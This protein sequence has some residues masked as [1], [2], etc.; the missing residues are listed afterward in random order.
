LKPW[1]GEKLSSKGSVATFAV[2]LVSYLKK[3]YTTVV[4]KGGGPDGNGAPLVSFENIST[5]LQLLQ[6]LDPSILPQTVTGLDR[7]IST[8]PTLGEN[9]RSLIEVCLTTH[10]S[11]RSSVSVKNMSTPAPG[12]P[13]NPN[14]TSD[15]VEEMATAYFQKIY[16]SEQSIGEVVE[17][18]KRFKTSGNGKENKIFACMV[19][20]LFDEYR[21]FA[22]YPEKEL[23]ITG[24]LV[25]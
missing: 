9:V 18:L 2:S 14:V 19:H 11:L 3:T 5:S 1:L 20:N 7:S 8:G 21:F 4:P 12:P 24:I 13:S 17:M 15:D 6:S 16:T 10:P 25:R 23:R 22:K